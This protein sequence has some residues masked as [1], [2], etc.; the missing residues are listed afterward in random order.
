MNINKDIE[1]EISG[2]GIIMYSDFAVQSILE[3]EDYFIESY[4][5]PQQVA[6]HVNEGSI[7]GFCTSSEGN[8]ILKVRSGYPIQKKIEDAEF[9][10]TLGIEVR[11]KRICIRDLYDL[12][13]WNKK[14]NYNQI[15]E[16]DNG[17]YNVILYGDIPETNVI[18]DNQ[19]IYVYLNRTDAIP[20]LRYDGVPI[21]CE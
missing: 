2:L 21:F 14:C 19:I 13:R 15:I 9:K 12:M 18:G 17:F 1:I 4:Q 7:V 3:G 8:Y 6:K 10:I 20:D 11:D 5:T 16:L